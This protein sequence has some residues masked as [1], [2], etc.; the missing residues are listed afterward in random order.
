MSNLMQKVAGAR[1]GLVFVWR[2]RVLVNLDENM[3]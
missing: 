3:I 2:I 1:G